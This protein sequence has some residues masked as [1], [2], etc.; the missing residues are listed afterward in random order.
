MVSGEFEITRS[1]SVISRVG[2][3][4]VNDACGML[5][6]EL[7]G[8]ADRRGAAERQFSRAIAVAA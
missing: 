3:R 5:K 2:V 7:I 1:S 8:V 4:S 6:G